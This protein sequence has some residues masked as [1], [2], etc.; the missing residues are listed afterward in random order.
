MQMYIILYKAIR[1]YISHNKFGATTSQPP[2]ESYQ[3]G[4]AICI[5]TQFQLYDQ[6]GSVYTLSYIRYYANGIY[7][8][9]CAGTGLLYRAPNN[10]GFLRVVV[11]YKF[12]QLKKKTTTNITIYY[13]ILVRV[14]H[15]GMNE[16]SNDK[17]GV[18]ES[19][20]GWLS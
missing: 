8:L 4:R 3:T 2:R 9:T 18:D 6:N 14:S 10:N 12:L 11:L 16:N 13:I 5:F 1:I 7:R 15:C 17:A 19:N 20:G